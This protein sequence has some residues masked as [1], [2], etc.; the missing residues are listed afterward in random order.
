MS[1]ISTAEQLVEKYGQVM[2]AIRP[3]PNQ[4]GE[5]A[6]Q[7]GTPNI[8]RLLALQS[9]GSSIDAA[10]KSEAQKEIR[11]LQLFVMSRTDKDPAT[12]Q[13]TWQTFVSYLGDAGLV[14][15]ASAT[16]QLKKIADQL[17]SKYNG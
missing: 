14:A 12:N 8:Q 7:A 16:K 11:K 9:S 5:I 17:S 6:R 2:Q 13:T 4:L 1:L 10:T 3:D 15:A